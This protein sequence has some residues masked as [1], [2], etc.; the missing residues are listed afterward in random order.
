MV[1]NGLIEEFE[2]LIDKYNLDQSCQS[3]SAIGYKE[4]FAYKNGDI[5]KE[6]LI[7]E[8]QKHTRRYA[9]RQI[10]WMKKYRE[11]PFTQEILMDNLTKDDASSIIMKTIKDI[12]EF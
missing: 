5:G 6:E 3:M 2:Y 12:Y 11:Y 8:I 9:K 4:I 10:T 7:E 1:S